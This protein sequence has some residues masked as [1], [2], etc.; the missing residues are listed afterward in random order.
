MKNRQFLMGILA[1]VLVFGFIIIG[2]PT[3]S[4]S[5]D[6]GGQV[7]KF[8]GTWKKESESEVEIFVFKNNTFTDTI[9]EESD[10]YVWQ[11]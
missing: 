2:C 7:N 9:T 5:S 1:I 8:E 11:G 3:D 6:G 10:D 4:D